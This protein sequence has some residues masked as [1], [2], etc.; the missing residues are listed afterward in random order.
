[1]EKITV[2]QEWRSQRLYNRSKKAMNIREALV[3]YDFADYV[4]ER[5]D[6][7]YGDT[8]S[9]V[10]SARKHEYPDMVGLHVAYNAE[11]EAYGVTTVLASMDGQTDSL[12][13]YL[14]FNVV[15]GR[16]FRDGD[17]PA[18]H[19]VPMTGEVATLATER[20][21]VG[22]IIDHMLEGAI[23]TVV[24]ETLQKWFYRYDSTYREIERKRE[25]DLSWRTDVKLDSDF[26]DL[27]FR[28]YERNPISIH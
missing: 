1:M 3:M 10:F 24:D 4:G 18:F 15:A 23:Y 25:G 22:R 11:M 13:D 5:S 16:H 14:P 20:L 28:W 27:K 26:L 21:S 19:E 17:I 2:P 6:V 12:L 9:V 8:E 7:K